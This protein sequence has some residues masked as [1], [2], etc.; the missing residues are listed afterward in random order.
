[1]NE[2]SGRDDSACVFLNHIP[3]NKSGF[4][5]HIFINIIKF[6]FKFFIFHSTIMHY[7]IKGKDTI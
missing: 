5:L 6:K 7:N 2:D 1:M 3:I 4:I